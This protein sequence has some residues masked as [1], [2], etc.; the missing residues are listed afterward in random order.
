MS[1]VPGY[2]RSN[3]RCRILRIHEPDAC[4]LDSTVRCRYRLV[5]T[6]RGGHRPMQPFIVPMLG[7]V[8]IVAVL[9]GWPALNRSLRKRRHR[10]QSRRA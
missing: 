3:R 1:A 7:F 6:L 8:G 5:S 4:N 9:F 10:K 2:P